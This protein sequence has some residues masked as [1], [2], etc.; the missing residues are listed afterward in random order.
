MRRNPARALLPVEVAVA[1]A[2]QARA[3]R[4]AE[5]VVRP[6]QACARQ[7]QE[8]AVTPANQARA[9]RTQKAVATAPSA[10]AGLRAEQAAA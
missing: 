9:R 3:R 8:E 1:V 5:E 6:N 7:P 2:N 10:P 4:P